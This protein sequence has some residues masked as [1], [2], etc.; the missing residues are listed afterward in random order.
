MMTLQ[1]LQTIDEVWRPYTHDQVTIKGTSDKHGPV[2]VCLIGKCYSEFRSG[3]S[4][5]HC[6]D[7]AYQLFGYGWYTLESSNYVGFRA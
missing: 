5:S 6:A 7:V 4:L 1:G 3:P 2:R